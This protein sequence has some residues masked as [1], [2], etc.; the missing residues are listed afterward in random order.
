MLVWRCGAFGVVAG[1]AWVCGV[2]GV[3]FEG[4]GFKG[5]KWGLVPPS[6]VSFLRNAAGLS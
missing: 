2:L 1:G 4:M 6:E 5:W 3:V